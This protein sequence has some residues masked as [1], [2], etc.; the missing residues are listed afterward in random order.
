MDWKINKLL[1][2]FLLVVFMPVRPLQATDLDSNYVKQYK[3][4]LVIAYYQ[5][6]RRYE[7]NVGQKINTDTLGLTKLKYLSP[8]NN[9]SGFEINYDK[10]SFS[11]GWSSSITNE[12]IVRKGRGNSSAY[13]FSFT[14]PIARLETSYRSYTG[15]Y[16]DN[17]SSLVKDFTKQ[18]PYIQKPSMQINSG[19]IKGLFFLNSKKRFSF[20]SAYSC[21]E[22]Q[23]QTAG[24]L[25]AMGSVQYI[26]M[27]SKT[28]IIPNQSA[29]YYGRY[30]YDLNQVNSI[31][32][33]FA[34]GYS[35]NI[36]LFKGLFF[37][38]T[39][40]LGPEL[41][42][43]TVSTLSG[44][45][46]TMFNIGAVSDFR[47][48]FGFNGERWFWIFNALSD[49]V[50]VAHNTVKYEAKYISGAATIGYRFK[51]REGKLI[52]KMKNNEYYKKL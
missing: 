44:V 21:T 27:H 18:T 14:L 43:K 38:G 19:K 2:L 23:L 26:G 15:F 11:F 45:S 30:Y 7:V 39:V 50:S 5:S 46:Y 52:S 51:L 20:M 3:N 12:D 28:S 4:R 42:V 35:F 49:N 32:Y 8:N 36:V 29:P 24:A 10:I 34:P 1:F 40:A 33:G 17:T 31:G 37:N 22:R 47:M 25:F 9:A 6:Y 48:G 13:A 41:Q 16:L